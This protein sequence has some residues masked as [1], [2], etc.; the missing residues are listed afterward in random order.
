VV[1]AVLSEDLEREGWRR[2]PERWAGALLTCTGGL[3][4]KTRA[5]TGR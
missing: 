4:D 2:T 3:R 5:A 1:L